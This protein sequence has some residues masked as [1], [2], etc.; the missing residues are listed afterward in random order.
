MFKNKK[1]NF[2]FVSPTNIDRVFA[3]Y[4]ASK[5]AG[6]CFVCDDYQANLLKIVSTNHKKSSVFYDIDYE[7]KT[8][9]KGRFIELK[10]HRGQ[11]FDFLGNLKPYLEKHGFC[12]IIRANHSFKPLLDEYTNNEEAKIHYSMWKGYIDSKSPAFNYNTSKFFEP[13]KIE[14][15]HTS[16][17]ADIK[18]LK[19]V[20][21]AVNPKSGI[22]PI[23]TEAPEKFNEVFSPHKIILIEDGK[24]FEV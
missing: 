21:Y 9:P 13:Y 10:N 14:F 19:N 18:T 16:G 1:Y 17:H 2:V 7:Q 22:I 8:D 20:F 6:R 12:M 15:M 23:H 3:L 11:A 4:H 5:R 24:S